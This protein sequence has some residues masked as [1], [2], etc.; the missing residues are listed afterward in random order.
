MKF[1]WFAEVTYPHI[2]E[3]RALYPSG[4]VDPNVRLTDSRTIGA[5]YRMFIRLLQLA[6]Q[7]GFDG[8]AVNERSDGFAFSRTATVW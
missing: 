3:D 1:H 2:P 7:V 6:D 4:W 8:L 5:T